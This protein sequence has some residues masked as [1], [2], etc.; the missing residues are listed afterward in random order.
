RNW[1]EYNQPLRDRRKDVYG[2]M[3]GSDMNVGWY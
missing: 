3:L 2:E 1:N